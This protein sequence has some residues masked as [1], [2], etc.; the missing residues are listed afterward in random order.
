MFTSFENAVGKNN[1][2]NRIKLIT[3]ANA[4]GKKVSDIAKETGVEPELLDKYNRWMSGDVIPRKFDTPPFL[5]PVKAKEEKPMVAKI[6]GGKG[7]DD[8]KGGKNPI[9]KK[10]NKDQNK[11]PVIT[12]KRKTKVGGQTVTLANSNGIEAVIP[13]KDTDMATLI[14]SLDISRNKFL[15]YNDMGISS[16][17]NPDLPYY[18]KKK[19]SKTPTDAEFHVLQYGEDLQEVSQR[20]SLKLKSLMRKNRIDEGE[21]VEPGRVLWLKKKRPRKVPVEI[22]DI[23]PKPKEE[24]EDDESYDQ[25]DKKKLDEILGIEKDDKNDEPV[26][27]IVSDGRFHVVQ[28]GETLYAISRAY[29][30]STLR[31]KE[32]NNLPEDLALT[33]GQILIV[34]EDVVKKPEPTEGKDPLAGITEEVVR[35]D[36]NGNIITGE[37][38]AK[39]PDDKPNTGNPNTVEPANKNALVH[40]VRPKENIY[41]IAKIYDTSAQDI[42]RWNKLD[43]LRVLES[44]QKLYVSD[45]D[46]K[47]ATGTTGGT[48]TS[49]PAITKALQKHTVAPGETLYGISRKYDLKVQEIIAWNKIDSQKPIAVGQVLLVEDPNASNSQTG[50]IADAGENPIYHTIKRGESIKTIAYDYGTSVEN[51]LALN[52]LTSQDILVEGQ[53][54][55]IKPRAN[56]KPASNPAET[57]YT[58][59]VNPTPSTGGTTPGAKAK[60]HTVRKGDTIYGLSRAYGVTVPEIR[61]WNG[62][63]DNNLS[64]GQKLM[65]GYDGSTPNKVRA[66]PENKTVNNSTGGPAQAVSNNT[67]QYI[68]EEPKKDGPVYHVVKKGDTLYSIARNNNLSVNQLKI[69]NEGLTS[70]LSIGQKI[71]VK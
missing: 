31:L 19:K 16:E 14:G 18:L 45:P 25:V 11:Y 52:N 47:V 17:L 34:R 67:G 66:T 57:V 59:P 24:E 42:V 26:N 48:P 32:L 51:I 27:P 63:K 56:K 70:T 8:N 23:G 37:A 68:K 58:P 50:S 71:R 40:I 6:G 9:V 28:K 62:L 15:K 46:A 12:A 41:T 54:L 61:A 43:P 64:I 60:T 55:L 38:P 53:T 65:V 30:I 21:N 39:K 44:G 13:A 69:L 49:K 7:N 1:D 33:P 22:K 3:Y 36:E 29:K 10:E 4:R 2:P 20:Y 5:V 35:I